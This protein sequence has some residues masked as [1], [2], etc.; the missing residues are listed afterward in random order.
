[1]R[2]KYLLRH[3]T[4]GKIEGRREMR[5]RRGGRHKKPLN[6]LEEARRMPSI[7][8]GSTRSHCVENSLR[9]RLWT[10]CKTDNKMMTENERRWGKCSTI[11]TARP[12][13][14]KY[15]YTR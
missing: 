10:C 15:G 14:N 8:R 12:L 4:E 3:A 9:R 11:K 13:R 2:R 1:L 7:E 5:E 6:D